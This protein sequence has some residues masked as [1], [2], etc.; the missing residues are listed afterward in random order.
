MWRVAVF[1][2]IDAL[3]GPEIAAALVDGDGQRRR[4]QRGAHVGG[5]VVGPLA[6]VHEERIAVGD[7]AIE[8][9]VEVAPDVRVRVL[10]DDERGAGVVHEDA[11]EALFHSRAA[12]DP[13]DVGGDLGGPT[14]TSADL[15]DPTMHH[16]AP[17]FIHMAL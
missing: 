5:H 11:G 16:S 14:T 15:E 17:I 13:L 2:E 10:V 4:G 3:P 12:H 9:G 1:E 8:E 6:R 7:Q